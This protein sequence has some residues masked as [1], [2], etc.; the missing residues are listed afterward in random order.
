MKP[1]S[2]SKAFA[3]CYKTSRFATPA[4][5]S[6][7]HY[8]FTKSN[9]SMSVEMTPDLAE[10][11][12]IHAGDGYMRKRG[13]SY[14]LE[15][16]GSFDEKEYYDSWVV[17][18]YEKVFGIKIT[19]QYFKTKG[20]YG[21]RCC[22]KEVAK[23][24]HACGFPYGKKTFTV[25]VPEQVLESRNLDIIYRFLR[26]VFDTDGCL[27]FKKRKGSGYQKIHTKRHTLVDIAFSSCSLCLR[28][29]VSLLLSLTGFHIS[30]CNSKKAGN[31]SDV[32]SIS[33]QGDKNLLLWM[34]NIGFKNTL[35]LNRFFIWKEN[36]FCPPCLDIKT[37]RKILSGDINPN[38]L[39]CD[40][41]NL[42]E[43]RFS[44]VAIRQIKLLQK[45]GLPI[46]K[47]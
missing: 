27:S 7:N 42:P 34:S 23:K 30:I 16:S 8:K 41:F 36:G 21:F 33:L 14:E 17:P 11:C 10:I 9:S 12:G 35:K 1:S 44:G 43:N 4:Q 38:L 3:E 2:K 37:Q 26:G 28:D 19:P 25:S 45:L 46:N 5:Y 18:L 40:T 13:N 6:Q 32:Y 24:L 22:K 39:Y 15:I 29:G 20:T 31:R 47:D